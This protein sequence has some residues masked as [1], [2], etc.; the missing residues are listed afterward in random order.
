MKRWGTIALILLAFVMGC[1]SGSILIT[2]TPRAPIT[3]NQVTLYTTPPAEYEVIGS[4]N[5]SS[6]AGLTQQ[7]SLDYAV[8]RLKSEAAKVG[9]NGVLI[10]YHGQ[11]SGDVT[12]VYVPTYGGGG[13]FVAGAS[14]V[15][16]VRGD[17]IWVPVKVENEEDGQ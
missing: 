10:N 14:G 5:A 1:A 16:M 7:G 2:G 12:G 9:A 3:I 4:I 17:A 6:D 15:M 13:M 11:T 8:E